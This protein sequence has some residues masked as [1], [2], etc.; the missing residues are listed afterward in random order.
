MRKLLWQTHHIQ[1]VRVFKDDF[2]P[3]LITRKVISGHDPTDKSHKNTASQ[4]NKSARLANKEEVKQTSREEGTSSELINLR[5]KIA[6][7]ETAT[8]TCPLEVL[9]LK[10]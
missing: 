2:V 3:D 6:Y 4:S 7:T 10:C 5:R 8:V 1:T 9:V